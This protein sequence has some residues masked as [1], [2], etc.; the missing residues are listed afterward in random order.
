MKKHF[1]DPILNPKTLNL[2]IYVVSTYIHPNTRNVGEVEV[3]HGLGRDN[4]CSLHW[5]EEGLRQCVPRHSPPPPGHENCTLTRPAFRWFHAYL[6]DR[7][8]CMVTGSWQSGYL[9]LTSGVPPGTVMGPVL[10]TI[11]IGNLLAASESDQNVVF[12]CFADDAVVCS[13]VARPKQRL[14]TDSIA[15][16]R[17]FPTPAAPAACSSTQT[18]PELWLSFLTVNQLRTKIAVRQK[19]A[20]RVVQFSELATSTKSF[21]INWNHSCFWEQHASSKSRLFTRKFPPI[22]CS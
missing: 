3:D 6:E 2:Y 15:A 17:S 12:R 9:P 16:Y 14:P 11:F 10:F 7:T 8:Q 22:L 5:P 18:K 20:V 21:L 1:G 19:R 13:A 4:G